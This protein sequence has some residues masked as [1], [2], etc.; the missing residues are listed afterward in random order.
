MRSR[1]FIIA[2]P[3]ICFSLVFAANHEERE[4]AEEG[5]AQPRL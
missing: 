2:H 3:E 4:E 1:E 5:L